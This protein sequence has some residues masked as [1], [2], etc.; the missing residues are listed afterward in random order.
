MSIQNMHS[1]KRKKYQRAVNRLVRTLNQDIQNDWLWNG[2]FVISQEWHTFKP[3]DDHSGCFF[4]VGLIITDKKTG[5]KEYG[6]FDNYEIEWKIWDWANY[7][8]TQIWEVWSENP[9]PNEQA[10]LEGRK[11]PAWR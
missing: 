6:Y 11:P 3:F 10:R 4:V 2:R 9:N 7:C 1:Q 8:I 5:Y